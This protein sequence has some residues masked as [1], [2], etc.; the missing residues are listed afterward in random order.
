VKR[1]AT[2][3]LPPGGIVATLG[4][5]GFQA[6][7]LALGWRLGRWPWQYKV[8]KAPMV[9]IPQGQIALLVAAEGASIPGERILAKVVDRDDFQDARKFLE[10]GGEQGRQLRIL[11]VGTFGI[12]LGLFTVIA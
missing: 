8:T 6:E 2:Q 7:T 10:N 3:T 5:A 4:E 12:N 9:V 1:F 11:T